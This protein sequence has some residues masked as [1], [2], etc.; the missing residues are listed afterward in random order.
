MAQQSKIEWTEYSWNP[1]TGCSKIS[2]GCAH[3]YAER[4]AC[5]LQAMGMKRY[6]SG[7]NVRTHPDLLNIPLKWRNPRVIFV[8]S[9]SDLFHEDIPTSFIQQ[10]FNIMNRC[11]QHTFQVL[12][13]RSHRLVELSEELRWT[14]NIWMGVT[15]E[16]NDVSHRIDHLREC[17]AR[18]KFLSC[19]PL[20]GPI[21]ELTLQ[22]IDWVIVG[23][24][25]GPNARLMKKE[26]AVSIRDQCVGANIPYFFKQWGGWNKKAAGRILDGR[27]WDEMPPLAHQ[28]LQEV[29]PLE[30]IGSV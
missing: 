6:E 22:G 23:G 5:R 27:I 1:V 13:K 10:V 29:P 21:E 17:S 14:H 9:M 2:A 25:S 24:E 8:N 3:C 4:I 11:P 16:N 20:I 18:V 12:T 15:V 7:F 28:A 30:L 19:E 26:W